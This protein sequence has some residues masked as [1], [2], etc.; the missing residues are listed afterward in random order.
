MSCLTSATDAIIPPRLRRQLAV[1]HL[2]ELT[3]ESLKAVVSLQLFTFVSAHTGAMD[4]STL[5]KVVGISTEVYSKVRQALKVSGMPG[6]Q[7]YIFSLRQLES[8]YQVLNPRNT[9]IQ[10]CMLLYMF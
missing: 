4:E 2:P 1:V 7:H 9:S 5:Q 3:G 8:A 6:R 10:S